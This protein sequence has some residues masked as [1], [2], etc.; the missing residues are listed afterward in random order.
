MHLSPSVLLGLASLGITASAAP[1]ETRTSSLA[2]PDDFVKVNG[3]GFTLNGGPFKFHGTNNYYLPVN[4]KQLTDEFFPVAES[5]QIKVIRTWAFADTLASQAGKNGIWFQSFNGTDV[6][7]NEGDDGLKML[8]YVVEQSGKRGMKLILA[9][10]NN[11]SD[12]GGMDLYV[13]AMGGTTH[14]DFYTNEKVKQTYMN[15][16]KNIVTRKNPLTGVPYNEDPAIFAWEL[17]NEA[18][19]KGSTLERG[20]NCSPATIAS[21]MT[22]MS[23]FVKSLDSNHLVTTG[24]EGFYARPDQAYPDN[25]SDGVDIEQHMQIPTI[26]YGTFHTYPEHFKRDPK[27]YGP[28]TVRD[29][30]ATAEKFGKPIVWEEYGLI[31][32]DTRAQI[33]P[34]W[35]AA[36]QQS[37]VS[38]TLVW[39]VAGP[40]YP[41]FDGFTVHPDDP[42]IQQL[43]KDPIAAIASGNSTPTGSP[44]TS[45]P[46]PSTALCAGTTV[47]ATDASARAWGFE[48]GQSC[49]MATCTGTTVTKTDTAGRAW[50]FENGK[51]CLVPTCGSTTAITATDSSARAWGFENGNSCLIPTCATTRTITATDSSARSWGFEDGRSCLIPTCSGGSATAVTSVDSQGR[52]WGFENG[53]SCLIPQ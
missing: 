17:T 42:F 15:Y 38:G 29:H 33:I 31:A 23:A 44:P 51:S 50:G 36:V 37:A 24:D 30:S 16:V 12:F 5:L 11:W 40:S 48:N 14:G 28:Q 18:R 26:D 25:G 35:H 7:I 3:T 19:C 27:T 52:R 34:E 39:M 53:F 10:V 13:E 20:D 32:K 6:K 2:A 4:S 45:T 21:W 9:L 8:D 46:A 22:E 1:V 43:I 47:T 41:D 49:L